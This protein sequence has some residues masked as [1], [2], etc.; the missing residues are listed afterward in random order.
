MP[1][2]SAKGERRG[3]RKRGVSKNLASKDAKLVLEEMART[4]APEALA[5]LVQVFKHG[6]TESARVAAATG[7]LD[8]A[9]GRPGQAIALSAKHDLRHMSDVEL[10]ALAVSF[11]S[12]GAQGG[13]AA[14]PGGFLAAPALAAP[15][16]PADDF[17]D[18]GLD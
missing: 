18:D 11:T 10:T 13:G 4:H 2:G 3:G 15:A 6:K 5:A 9:F 8:R 1:A 16:R 14:R 12:G 17:G 7:L